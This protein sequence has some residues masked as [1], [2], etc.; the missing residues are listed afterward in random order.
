MHLAAARNSCSTVRSLIHLGADTKLQDTD[1]RTVLHTIVLYNS[2]LCNILEDVTAVSFN[3]MNTPKR[4]MQRNNIQLLQS[5]MCLIPILEVPDK[6][7]NTALH[8]AT[9]QG[10]ITSI[11][12]LLTLGASVTTKNCDGDNMFHVACRYELNLQRPPVLT[13]PVNLRSQF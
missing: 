13:H 8:I 9:K 2:D 5:Q 7:G 4:E 10:Q 6:R 11:S 1:G 12:K 3:Y